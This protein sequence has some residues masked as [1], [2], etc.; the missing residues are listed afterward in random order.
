MITEQPEKPPF[1][2]PYIPIDS[3]P[4]GVGL[5]HLQQR[6][7]AVFFIWMLAA[8][9]LAMAVAGQL[10]E[11]AGYMA[12]ALAVIVAGLALALAL[13]FWFLSGRQLS[14]LEAMLAQQF[15]FCSE[16]N[17]VL[18]EAAVNRKTIRRGDLF[19]ALKVHF[20]Q[21]DARERAARKAAEQDLRDQ[22]VHKFAQQKTPDQ[23]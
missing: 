17:Q 12:T 5:A 7:E 3:A 11:D 19:R 18:R 4:T 1:L 10:S 6:Q 21:E 9:A 16:A 13:L 2:Q 8:I 20:G 14:Q 23:A 15:P 22:A